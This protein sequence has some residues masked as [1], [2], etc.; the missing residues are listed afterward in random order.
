MSANDAFSTLVLD[1]LFE[2]EST[3]PRLADFAGRAFE[4]SEVLG[5]L[6]ISDWLELLGRPESPVLG[7]VTEAF[8]RH[9]DPTRLDTEALID[10]A[11][12]RPQ[13]VA[14]VGLDLL[15]ERAIR[16]QGYVEAKP[17]V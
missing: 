6:L 3:D 9:V 8:K 10:L 2:S 13:P 12:A 4:S 15:R 16:R 1:E 11:C 5:T 14:S 7:Q 17:T